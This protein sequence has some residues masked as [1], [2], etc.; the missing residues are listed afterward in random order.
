MHKIENRKYVNQFGERNGVSPHDLLAECRR[1]AILEA[2]AAKEEVLRR[3]VLRYYDGCT[4]DEIPFD[5]I[6]RS[7]QI[8]G[9]DSYVNT[10]TGESI[11]SFSAPQRTR[12]R[13]DIGHKIHV[14]ISYSTFD[15]KK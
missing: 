9:S 14:E 3:A 2:D 1:K 6:I 13:D 12:D 15:G 10:V 5:H 8:D 7:T 4:E 11:V